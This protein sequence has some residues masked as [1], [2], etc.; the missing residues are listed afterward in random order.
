[1][2]MLAIAMAGMLLLAGCGPQAQPEKQKEQKERRGS[3]AAPAAPSAA[4]AIAPTA[5]MGEMI[6]RRCI[7]C[8]TIEQGGSNG[9][10]PNLYGVVDRPRAALAN[11]A[12]SNAMKAKGGLWDEA[13]L[14]AY[15]EQPMMAIPGTRMAFAGV[16]DPADRKA[17][18]LYLQ[19]NSP[20]PNGA[21]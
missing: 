6:F 12:Y 17:L 13:A 19:E 15:L 18:Y 7:A 14:D 20:A 2:R 1:M 8:H 11:F 9:I 3:S 5:K 16:I 4:S 10:G 21:D